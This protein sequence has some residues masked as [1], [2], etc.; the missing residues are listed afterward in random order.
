MCH[1]TPAQ[2]RGSVLLGTVARCWVTWLHLI[3]LWTYWAL[4]TMHALY[5]YLNLF[6]IESMLTARMF[7]VSNSNV[8]CS[9]AGVPLVAP[10]SVFLISRYS[11][12]LTKPTIIAC[13][14]TT[15]LISSIYSKLEKTA[16]KTSS[17]WGKERTAGESGQQTRFR[18][19]RHMLEACRVGYVSDT[20]RLFEEKCRPVPAQE[21]PAGPVQPGPVLVYS[22]RAD[23]PRGGGSQGS[24]ASRS[25]SPEFPPFL[26]RSTGTKDLA[27]EARE[28]KYLGNEQEQAPV[29][30]VT[31]DPTENGKEV[32]FQIRYEGNVVERAKSNSNEG[33]EEVIRTISTLRSNEAKQQRRKREDE[34]QTLNVSKL[35][36][37]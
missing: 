36:W 14:R 37:V 9:I 18:R 27:E 7:H 24:A 19:V 35:F 11:W 26:S 6:S 20:A 13:Y 8:D 29:V 15:T 17:Q 33:A 10:I 32:W 30:V 16:Q 25:S 4:L 1:V 22:R 34:K 31:S 12:L 28:R 3:R 2:Y 21:G 5:M 23:R